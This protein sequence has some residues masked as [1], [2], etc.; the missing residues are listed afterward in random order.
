MIVELPVD[1]CTARC[2]RLIQQQRRAQLAVGEWRA[3]QRQG[4]CTA[5]LTP[6]A[7][8]RL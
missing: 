1:L 3:A 4:R 5:A 6:I 2:R 8:R 7:M